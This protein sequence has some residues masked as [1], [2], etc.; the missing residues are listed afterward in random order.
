MQLPS[1]ANIAS[2][3]LRCPEGHLERVRPLL[4]AGRSIVVKDFAQ[5]PQA[6]SS[7]FF[8]GAVPLSPS[9]S[10]V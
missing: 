8:K 5:I 2:E 3:R 6:A 9:C 4:A 7:E 1:G 10:R